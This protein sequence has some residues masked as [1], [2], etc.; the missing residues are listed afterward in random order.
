LQD[1]VKCWGKVFEQLS[2]ISAPVDCK[3]ITISSALAML[4]K[5]CAINAYDLFGQ[6]LVINRY[7]E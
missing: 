2:D 1:D 7:D 3:M 5:N 6:I 4:A